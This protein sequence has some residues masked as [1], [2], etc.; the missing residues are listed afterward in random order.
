MTDKQFDITLTVTSARLTDHDLLLE[1]IAERPRQ[2]L[3]DAY[4]AQVQAAFQNA[5]PEIQA[6]LASRGLHGGTV[7]VAVVNAEQPL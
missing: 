1:H 7:G 5:L 4:R 3:Q 6:L 2:D